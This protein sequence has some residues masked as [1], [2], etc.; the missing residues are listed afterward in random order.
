M[1]QDKNN[2]S[3]DDVQIN[4]RF[5][6]KDYMELQERFKKYIINSNDNVPS[7]QQWIRETLLA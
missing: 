2:K 4:I 1:S 3:I 5:T 6:K 7:I